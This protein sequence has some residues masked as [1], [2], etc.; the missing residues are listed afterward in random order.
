M[1]L[2]VAGAMMALAWFRW[3]AEL[4]QLDIR[5]Q[6]AGIGGENPLRVLN[7]N[8]SLFLAQAFLVTLYVRRYSAARWGLTCFSGALFLTVILLQHRSVWVATALSCVVI[9]WHER[10]WKKLV[11]MALA[12]LV[13]CLPLA[14]LESNYATGVAA[15][16]RSSVEE[17]F[18]DENSTI[19]W[20]T[21]LWQEYL[22]E[23]LALTGGQTWFGAG[24]GNPATYLVDG[25]EVSNSAHNYYV[26]TL[27]RA[28]AVGLI[29]LLCS[30]GGLIYRLRGVPGSWDYLGL[31]GTLTAGQILYFM[32]YMPSYE[33]G[34]VSGVVLGISVIPLTNTR[35][36][37]RE[38][39]CP[40]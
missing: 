40:I 29:L 3:A 16:L 14:L 26:F 15:S 38:A 8:Q 12:A 17:P 23:Y 7:A 22:F 36:A 1:W 39:T 11:P 32:A 34:L 24:Y 28:G 21:E 9:V 2:W 37:E 5:S 33:Q 18:D 25:S 20:R 6:W 10:A 13:L 27:N 30:Y 4:L 19:A 31:L 35:P